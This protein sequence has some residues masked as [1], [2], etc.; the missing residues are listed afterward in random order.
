[1]EIGEIYKT[2]VRLVIFDADGTLT[3][4]RPGSIASFSFQL[5][6][7]VEQRCADLRRAGV[8]LAI[9]SNQSRRRQRDFIVQQLRW[10]QLAIG[11]SAIRWSTT[12][13]RRKPRP[14][15]LLELMRKFSCTPEETIFVGDQTTDEEAARAAGVRFV[16]SDQFFGFEERRKQ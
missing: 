4:Q 7:G 6:P 1:M 13:R 11:A 16:W 10:T 2:R 12:H 8:K 5:L 14:A 3:P 9:A 15:M